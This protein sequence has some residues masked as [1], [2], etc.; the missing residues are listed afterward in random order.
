MSTPSFTSG[1]AETVV[2][3]V[4]LFRLRLKRSTVDFRKIPKI[5][6]EL[7]L[8]TSQQPKGERF[9]IRRSNIIRRGQT[10][11]LNAL[12][13]TF[14]SSSLAEIRCGRH[15][16]R[17]SFSVIYEPICTPSTP[18]CPSDLRSPALTVSEISRFPRSVFH[19]S[20]PRYRIQL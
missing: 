20:R 14:L 15:N 7:T 4:T 1:D 19:P 6:T 8:R 5:F 10:A 2:T 3:E 12:N 16:L 13:I 18:G 9:C 11:L 17:T